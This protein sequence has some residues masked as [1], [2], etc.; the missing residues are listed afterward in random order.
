MEYFIGYLFRIKTNKIVMRILFFVL[1]LFTS[2]ISNAQ[3]WSGNN[4]VAKEKVTTPLVNATNV[5]V[6]TKITTP[7]IVVNGDSINDV[8]SFSGIGNI[9]FGML[10]SPLKY[11]YLQGISIEEGSGSSR[12]GITTLSGGTI[13]VYNSSITANDRLFLTLK[14]CSNCGTIYEFARVAGI[15]FTI[16]STSVTDASSVVWCIIKPN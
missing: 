9:D 1:L 15:S 2:F 6:N 12:M 13:T 4:V 11:I 16:K 8:V 14:G 5:V 7:L 10:S 3:N